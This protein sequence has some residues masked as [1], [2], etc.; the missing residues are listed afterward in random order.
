VT[1]TTVVVP[2]S[3]RGV[4]LELRI[5]AA[6]GQDHAEE[7]EVLVAADGPQPHAED[8]LS[9]CVATGVRY[10]ELPPSDGRVNV[11]FHLATQAARGDWIAYL[12]ESDVWSLRHLGSLMTAAG[13]RAALAYSRPVIARADGSYR[14]QLLRPTPGAGWQSL[15]GLTPG[16]VIHRRDVLDD[17]GGWPVDAASDVHARLWQDIVDTGAGSAVSPGPTALHL[18][19]AGWT[20]EARAGMQQQLADPDQACVLEERLDGEAYT[21]ALSELD[22]AVSAEMR[23]TAERALAAEQA[24]DEALARLDELQATRWWRLHDRVVAGLGRFEWL[25]RS[26]AK[27]R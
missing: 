27:E 10:L 14:Q 1:T 13:T 25:G 6:T 23:A 15:R 17:V 21:A 7:I 24:R 26:N 22:A 18:A 12:G 2:V 19:G 8:A 9:R 16:F 5:R 20:T 4:D 3:G 11:L